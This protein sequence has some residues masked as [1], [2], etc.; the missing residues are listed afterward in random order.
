MV[1]DEM[2]CGEMQVSNVRLPP[3]LQLDRQDLN[4]GNMCCVSGVSSKRGKR[5]RQVLG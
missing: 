5:N 2:V 3:F 1:K 4:Q